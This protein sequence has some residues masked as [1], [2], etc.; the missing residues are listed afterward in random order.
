MT[1]TSTGSVAFRTYR[2][3]PFVRTA[4]DRRL[5][6]P[7]VTITTSA[8]THLGGPRLASLVVCLRFDLVEGGAAALNFGDDVVGCCLPDEGFR[9]VVP[10]VGPGGDLAGEFGDAGEDTPT[11][12]SVGEFLE[13]P[14]DQVQPRT[15]GRGEVQVPSAPVA[16]AY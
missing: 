3:H 10:V 12:A 15:R 13:P 4:S 11:E 8:D 1:I 6:R 7:T 9:V 2:T 5:P 16:M 14:L